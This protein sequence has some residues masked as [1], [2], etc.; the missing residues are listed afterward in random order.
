MGFHTTILVLLLASVPTLSAAQSRNKLYVNTSVATQMVQDGQADKDRL[1]IFY[2]TYLDNGY[3]D[4]QS[5]TFNNLSC[6]EKSAT[7]LTPNRG[8]W[9][10]PGFCNKSFCGDGFVCSAQ[11]ISDK[12]VEL[13]VKVP[14]DVTGEL[15]HRVLVE[16][17]RVI[18]YAGTLS[19]YSDI[20]DRIETAHYAPLRS[21][22]FNPFEDVELGC[23]KMT[24]PMIPTRQ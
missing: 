11:N 22:S 20:T 18:D 19:K 7:A 24:V 17:G 8:L 14:V 13:T 16:S 10:N 12:R 6:S 3:C 2:F 4:V 23:A 15:T 21:K 1:F 9:P 5:I